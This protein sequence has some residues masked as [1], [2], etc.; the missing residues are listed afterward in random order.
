M[1]AALVLA[2]TARSVW[3]SGNRD[4]I[5]RC[6]SRALWPDV[7]HASVDHG[8]LGGPVEAVR[9]DDRETGLA[10]RKLPRLIQQHQRAWP[11][12]PGYAV[13]AAQN[14]TPSVRLDRTELRFVRDPRRGSARG[15]HRPS[16]A[17]HEVAIVSDRHVVSPI[18]GAAVHLIFPRAAR[19]SSHSRAPRP[20]AARAFLAVTRRSVRV[21]CRAP[22][23]TTSALAASA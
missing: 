7:E 4:E 13:R 18:W 5:A 23:R 16:R 11:S 20:S 12:T 19:F 8:R 17:G 15:A 9:D 3:S 6:E 14:D 10:R 2:A 1:P 21:R 22:V